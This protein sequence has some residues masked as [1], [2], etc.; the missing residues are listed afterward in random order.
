MS[1]VPKAKDKKAIVCSVLL[2]ANHMIHSLLTN[3]ISLNILKL[4]ESK[5]L[6]TCTLTHKGLH[7]KKSKIE[8]K[9]VEKCLSNRKKKFTFFLN[10]ICLI[11]CM[12]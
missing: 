10:S 6:H 7:K 8:K 11:L 2:I 1:K 3:Q 4:T 12:L 5:I 9:E